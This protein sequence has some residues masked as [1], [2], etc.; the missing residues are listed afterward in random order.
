MSQ[1]TPAPE[2]ERP[3]GIDFL[4]ARINQDNLTGRFGGRV[5]TRFPPEP[6]GYLHIGHVKSICIDF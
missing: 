3:Q 4:R 2:A 6:N 5:H 1:N